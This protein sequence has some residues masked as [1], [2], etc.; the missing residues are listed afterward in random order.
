M[1]G[2]EIVTPADAWVPVD[3]GAALVETDTLTGRATV[4]PTAAEAFTPVAAPVP[5]DPAPGTGDD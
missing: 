1:T 3:A 5:E 2:A 4:A